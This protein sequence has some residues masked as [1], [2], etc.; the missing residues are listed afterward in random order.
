LLSTTEEGGLM[1]CSGKKSIFR[2]NRKIEKIREE[3]CQNASRRMC[4]VAWGYEFAGKISWKTLISLARPRKFLVCFYGWME[5][6]KR[7]INQKEIPFQA[8]EFEF[9]IWVKSNAGGFQ[10]PFWCH[11]LTLSLSLSLSRISSHSSYALSLSLSPTL[12]SLV[13]LLTLTLSHS[14]HALSLSHSFSFISHYLASSLTPRTRSRA[15][16]LSLSLTR[17][18]SLFLLRILFHCISKFLPI[19]PLPP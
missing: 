12:S 16:S 18:L 17:W 11:S 6:E 13:L 19:S 7:S 9:W 15:L 4:K 5:K 3:Y 14:S 2:E 8:L 1:Y 10:G